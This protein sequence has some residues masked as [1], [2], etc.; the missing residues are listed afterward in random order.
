MHGCDLYV[1]EYGTDLIS[2]LLVATTGYYWKSIE[3]ILLDISLQP[4]G[5]ETWS[6]CHW[7]PPWTQISK[8]L[9]F[10]IVFAKTTPGTSHLQLPNAPVASCLCSFYGL[11][12]CCDLVTRPNLHVP[13]G[14]QTCTCL[15]LIRMASIST[16]PSG[17]IHTVILS[18]FEWSGGHFTWWLCENGFSGYFEGTW[19]HLVCMVRVILQWVSHLLVT[20]N[21]LNQ[22][23]TSKNNWIAFG[24]VHYPSKCCVRAIQQQTKVFFSITLHK[25]NLYQKLLLVHMCSLIKTIEV[26]QSCKFVICLHIYSLSNMTK[27]DWLHC[28]A[29]QHIYN[30]KIFWQVAFVCNKIEFDWLHICT[31]DCSVCATQKQIW[32]V[33]HM[34]LWFLSGCWCF[35]TRSLHSDIEGPWHK[36]H[37]PMPPGNNSQVFPNLMAGKLDSFMKSKSQ[38]RQASEGCFCLFV[39][40]LLLLLFLSG[41]F[42]STW[43]SRNNWKVFRTWIQPTRMAEGCQKYVTWFGCLFLKIDVSDLHMLAA[44]WTAGFLGV[45]FLLALRCCSNCPDNTLW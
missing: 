1:G 4:S 34:Q 6:W 26:Q 44:C 22:M 15:F 11:Q 18:N 27:L 14:H 25:C 36:K 33:A 43:L 20:S 35:Q 31:K 45:A 5:I 9:K 19:R 39:Y 7:K 2:V 29:W 8:M 24:C 28:A 37:A 41:H 38:E 12:Y 42:Q 17:T 16:K 10:L 23:G 21:V 32:W 30:T 3:N 13:N 40:L